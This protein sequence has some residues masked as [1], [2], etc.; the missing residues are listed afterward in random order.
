MRQVMQVPRREFLRLGAGTALLPLASRFA[1]ADDYPSRPVHLLVGFAAA[2][3]SDIAARLVSQALSERLGQSFIV[4]NRPGAG[5]NLATE[6]VV[7][8]APDGYTLLLIGS[9]NAVNATL[10]SD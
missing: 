3:P 1:F 10:Y 7:N 6:T 9:P 4:E 5:S 8:A 2:G